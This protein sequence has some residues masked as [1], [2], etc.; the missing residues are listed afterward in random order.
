MLDTNRD[1]ASGTAERD[2]FDLPS[3]LILWLGAAVFLA[4]TLLLLPDRPALRWVVPVT[5]GVNIVCFAV[6]AAL[7]ALDARLR[8][9]SASLPAAAIGVALSVLWLAH[10]LTLPATL[11]PLTGRLDGTADWIYLLVN[12][13]TPT[14]PRFIAVPLSLLEVRE[15]GYAGILNNTVAFERK[16]ARVRAVL[17]ELSVS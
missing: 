8:A 16:K 1:D 17:L 12:T 7:G 5:D 6:I 15:T 4:V 10:L 9:D 11:P 14:M 3:A 2:R 13:A